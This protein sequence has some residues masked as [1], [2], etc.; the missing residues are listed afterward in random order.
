MLRYTPR[1]GITFYQKT[2]I[3]Q[4]LI[5]STGEFIYWTKPI[6]KNYPTNSCMVNA[7]TILS[8]Q[9]LS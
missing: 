6:V 7:A 4:S 1:L 5:L 8:L 9:S 2:Y 3:F